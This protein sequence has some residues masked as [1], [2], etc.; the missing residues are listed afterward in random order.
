[1]TTR[2]PPAVRRASAASMRAMISFSPA[3]VPATTVRPST[4][5]SD[6]SQM[7]IH[8]TMVGRARASALLTSESTSAGQRDEFGDRFV[9]GRRDLSARVAAP[10][11]GALEC[12]DA[13]RIADRVEARPE[14]ARRRVADEQNALVA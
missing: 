12:R 2:A 5:R 1:M 4:T 3:G 7:L 9:A 14:A 6:F 13:G 11:D 10:E 8:R